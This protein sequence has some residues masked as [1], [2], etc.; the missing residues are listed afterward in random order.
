MLNNSSALFLFSYGINHQLNI[1]I[2][3]RFSTEISK[4]V[5][6]IKTSTSYVIKAYEVLA[7]SCSLRIS[8]KSKKPFEKRISPL[9]KGKLTNLNLSFLICHHNS[10]HRSQKNNRCEFYKQEFKPMQY[11]SCHCQLRIIE[12]PIQIKTILRCKCDKYYHYNRTQ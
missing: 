8:V 12:I 11:C 10:N 3:T 6:H 2:R 4:A 7:L 1:I 5:T 9:S